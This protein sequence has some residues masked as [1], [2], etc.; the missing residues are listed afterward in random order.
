MGSNCNIIESERA[1]L[2]ALESYRVLDTPAEAVFD[3]IAR[4]AALVGATPT[5]LVS[6]VD[7]RRQWFKARVGLDAVETARSVA[8]CDHAIR[9]RD[10]LVVEDAT[11][12]ARFAGNPLVTGE[13]GIRFYAGAPLI[14][15]D[16]HAL[17]T[18]CVIDYVPRRFERQ[19]R[20]ALQAL[21]THAMSQ[22][23]LRRRLAH[24]SRSD[25]ASS[26]VVSELRSAL[27]GGEFTLH[28]LPV[29][30]ARTGAMDS[31]EALLRWQHPRRGL[32]GPSQFLH[33]LEESGLI[34]EVGT[35][36]L[37]RAAADY[38]Q[39][40]VEGLI[41]PRVSVNVASLQIRHPEFIAQLGYALDPDGASRVPLDIEISEDV[42]M[43]NPEPTIAKLQEAADMGVQVAVDDF[44][45]GDLSLRRLAHLPIDAL[46]IDR[47]LVT[48]MTESPD[49]LSIVSSI[50]SLAHTLNFSVIAEGVATEEQRKLLTL[51]RCDRMQ[52][53]LFTAPLTGAQ[54]FEVL[55]RDQAFAL[56]EARS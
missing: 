16:G 48:Q 33:L 30:D 13:P 49:G 40:L 18:V 2:E 46:K 51:L 56:Q 6:L 19:E 12:D 15:P 39:W 1:R 42:L 20:E 28:Y 35:W 17:G 43:H 31:L 36:V 55:R 34:V 7:G 9:G 47:S 21:A 27:D 38:R 14:T 26:E 52:G 44:G 23:D 45:T 3:E 53:F 29:Y 54:V 41:A 5:A 50:L 25:R 32:L 8:F 4:L 10:V 37:N 22:L 24:F 11:R